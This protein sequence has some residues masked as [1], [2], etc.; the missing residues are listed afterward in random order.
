MGTMSTH[1]RSCDIRFLSRWLSHPEQISKETTAFCRSSYKNDKTWNIPYCFICYAILF[2]YLTPKASSFTPL[3]TH[4]IGTCR[5]G[6]TWALPGLFQIMCTHITKTGR[7]SS[8]LLPLWILPS[9]YHPL[10]LP[11]VITALHT[12]TTFYSINPLRWH[13]SLLAK[14]TKN[15]N[16]GYSHDQGLS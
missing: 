13:G 1:N 15:A 2:L 8:H 5:P 10:T 9:H 16:L 11:L 3:P 6:H 7:Y 14:V 12:T 4:T